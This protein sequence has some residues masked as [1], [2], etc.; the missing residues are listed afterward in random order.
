MTSE[1]RLIA[2]IK[3]ATPSNPIISKDLECYLGVSGAAV[4]DIVR[5]LRR[6]GVPVGSSGSG[7]FYARSLE[8]YE[9]T[10][11]DLEHRAISLL[12]TVS[13]MRSAYDA[14][15]QTSLF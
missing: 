2:R 10:I 9:P 6:N 8:E 14:P 15:T 1:E 13:A 7:Y 3:K 4:R 5:T 12:N 11:T